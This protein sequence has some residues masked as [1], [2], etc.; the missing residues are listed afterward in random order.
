[1]RWIVAVICLLLIVSVGVANAKVVETTPHFDITYLSGITP[2]GASTLGNVL[3]NSYETVNRVFGT[4][5]SCHIKVLVVGKKA[6]DS[7]GEHVEAFSAW[8][9]KSSAIVLRE[10]SINDKKSLAVVTKHEITHL[11]LN[12][13]LENKKNDEFEWMQEGT[14]MLISREPLDDQKISRYIVSKGFLTPSEIQPAVDSDKYDV[15]KNGYF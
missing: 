5:P 3:E 13:I 1:M 12:N 10:S 11:A 9:Q 8:N 2:A 6:M 14:A 4:C 15:T 7:V